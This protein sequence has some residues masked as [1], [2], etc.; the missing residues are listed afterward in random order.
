VQ[1]LELP[2][3]LDAMHIEKNIIVSMIRTMSNAKGV[4]SDS[5]AVRQEMVA[6]NMMPALHPH[7]TDKLDKEG[8]P[9]Y[10][11]TKPTPWVWSSHD[12]RKVLDIIKNV[13]APSNYGSSLAYKIGDKQIGGFKTHDWHN[14]LHDL[15]PIAIHGTLTEGIREMVY[16]LSDLFKLCAKQIQVDDI[17]ILE[18]EAAEVI[19]LM[20]M[21]FPPSFFDIQPHHIVHLPTELLMAGPIRPCWMY[22]VERHLW[23]L[24]GWVRQ[25]A[26]PEA[27]VTQEAIKYASEYCANLYPSW[28]PLPVEV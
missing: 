21:N 27:Y 28:A 13:C 5:L 19:C 22:F 8:K 11:Y 26:R 1:D 4:K 16:R 14:V 23:V 6:R 2:H 20:K 15:L 18:R 10:R 25:K 7:R 12:F 24:K 17:V 3:L 9:I